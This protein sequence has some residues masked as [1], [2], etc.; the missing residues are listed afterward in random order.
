[1]K[2]IKLTLPESMKYSKSFYGNR[3]FIEFVA[4]NNEGTTDIGFSSGE[5]RNVQETIK[6][7]K[8]MLVIKD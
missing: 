1:M 8:S 4:E 6:V 2:T 7:V 5:T 3:D